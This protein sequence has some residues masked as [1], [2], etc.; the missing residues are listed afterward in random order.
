MTVWVLSISHRHGTNISAY[1]SQEGALN[2][3]AEYVRDNWEQE[4]KGP[5]PAPERDPVDK[6][7][8]DESVSRVAGDE[9]Y[10][11]DELEVLP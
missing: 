6:Y 7:F 5:L 4:C 11:I 8:Y 2:G 10:D 3:L 9:S 1:A